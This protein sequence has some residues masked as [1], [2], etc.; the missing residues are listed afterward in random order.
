MPDRL[1]QEN[2]W[3]FL[4]THDA[5]IPR[6][7]V[8]ETAPFAAWVVTAPQGLFLWLVITAWLLVHEP[9]ASVAPA[10]T[11]AAVVTATSGACIYCLRL[12]LR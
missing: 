10:G 4:V 2:A 7:V 12:R 8:R 3:I 9:A 1:H 6:C 5:S 11:L